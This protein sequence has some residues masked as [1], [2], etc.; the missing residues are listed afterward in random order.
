MLSIFWKHEYVI[1]IVLFPRGHTIN[2]EYYCDLLK[3]IYAV[4]CESYSARQEMIQ[5]LETM[6]ICWREVGRVW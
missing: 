6:I 3:R 2:S 1:L 5:C 4:L